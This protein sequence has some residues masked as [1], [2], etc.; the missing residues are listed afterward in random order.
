MEQS[1]IVF[2][3]KQQ[4]GKESGKVQTG[5]ELVLKFGENKQQFGKVQTGKGEVVLKCGEGFHSSYLQR[6]YNSSTVGS[7][8][9][10]RSLLNDN[11]YHWIYGN[12]NS[13]IFVFVKIS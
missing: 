3:E 6:I 7:L 4:F 9:N 8:Q 12:Y 11:K 1:G 2:G 10:K 5:R 13:E